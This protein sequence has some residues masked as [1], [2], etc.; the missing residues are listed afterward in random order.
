MGG[1]GLNRLGGG[2]NKARLWFF[3]IFFFRFLFPFGCDVA[4]AAA[5]PVG[6]GEGGEE[7]RRA[8][9]DRQEREK[10]SGRREQQLA[11]ITAGTLTEIST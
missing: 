1:G 3:L 2:H 11:A 8:D 10:Q 6:S 5:A 9:G 4:K 7:T